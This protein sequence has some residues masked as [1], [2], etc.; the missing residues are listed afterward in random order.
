MKITCE[1][2]GRDDFKD[3][4]KCI[5]HEKKCCKENTFTC[6]KCGKIIKWKKDD[7]NAFIIENQCHEINLGMLGYGSELDNVN[8][9]F[10]LCDSCLVN[11]I[12][13]FKLK[14]KNDVLNSTDKVAKAYEKL[15]KK[16]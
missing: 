11:F 16:M 8:I 2:C 15:Y 13:S 7:P 5:Q 3:I 9:S 12:N 14:L 4:C 1:K 6:H 10:G